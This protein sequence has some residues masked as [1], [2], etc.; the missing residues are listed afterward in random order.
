MIKS[1]LI[2]VNIYSC[3]ILIVLTKGG[4][5]AAA[6]SSSRSWYVQERWSNNIVQN[7]FL[8]TLEMFK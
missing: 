1:D 5:K 7:T 4:I 3:T 2:Y 6:L 8:N